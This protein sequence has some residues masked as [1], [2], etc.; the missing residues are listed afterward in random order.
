MKKIIFTVALFALLTVANIAAQSSGFTIT[1]YTGKAEWSVYAN[2]EGDI[3][4]VY[5]VPFSGS[6]RGYGTIQA[7]GKVTWGSRPFG[8]TF[9]L[10]II[11]DDNEL[12]R[13]TS[14]VTISSGTG[15][16]AFSSFVIVK[17]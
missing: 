16:V 14:E 5:E 6:G 17:E 7:D 8:S 13:S 1:G 15:E 3:T 12:L 11:T 10:Y 9:W 2:T 4:N